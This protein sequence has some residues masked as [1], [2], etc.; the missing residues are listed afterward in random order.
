M[1]KY[2]PHTASDIKEMLEKIGV[3]NIDDLFSEIPEAVKY[4]TEFN[5]E[6]ALSE[7]ELRKRIKDIANKNQSAICFLGAGAYDVYTPAIIPYL[8]MRQEFLTAYTPYQPEISQGTLQYIFEFQSMICELTGMD[9]SNASVY[10][11]ATATAEAMFMA[12]AHTKRNTVLVSKTVNPRTIDVLKTYASFRNIKIKLIQEDDFLTTVSD[13]KAKL[14]DDIAAVIVQN[15][16]FFGIIED[17]RELSGI[18][19]ANKSLLIINVDPSTLSLL[20]TPGEIGA[21]IA[22]GDGQT[23]G[24]P[25]S[26]GGPYVGFIA[27]AK[28]LLRKIP[29]RICGMTND[30]DGK[31]G[32]VLTLQ[33]RE[34]HIRREKATSNICSNQSLMALHNVIYLSLLGKKGLKEVAQRAVN[35]AHYLQDLLLQTGLFDKANDNPFFKEFVLRTHLDIDALNQYLFTY[36]ILSGLNLA[37]INGKYQNQILFCATE[38]RTKEEIEKLVMKVEEYANV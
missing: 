11:G 5:L 23:L 24:V 6:S 33:A 13:L 36:G 17:H 16:N 27:A 31:S 14:T 35:N 20:T 37:K 18:V 30:I 15:P 25:L 29:G 28:S 26:F 3:E 34:Q 12:T 1:F 19:K 22:C 2:I 4:H 38:M 7:V 8:I 21:D 32:Y 9:V 10:D